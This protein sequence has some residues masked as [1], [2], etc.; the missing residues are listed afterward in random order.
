M[1]VDDDSNDSTRIVPPP[2]PKLPVAGRPAATPSD[3][4]T[5]IQ[6][7]PPPAP[8]LQPPPR[9]SAPPP[10]PPAPVDAANA[11]GGD[12][13]TH[14]IG[15]A[16]PAAK[17]APPPVSPPPP[18]TTPEVRAP[19][20]AQ[21]TASSVAIDAEEATQI[22]PQRRVATMR[23]QRVQPPG[24]SEMIELDRASYL[25]GRSVACDLT[26]YSPTASREH[27]R[28]HNQGGA[29]FIEPVEAREVNVDG[30]AIKESTRLV[31]AMRL[32][33]GGDE[34]IFL[35][36]TA[37]RAAAAAAAPDVRARF[38]LKRMV[39]IVVGIALFAVA[40]VWWLTKP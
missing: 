16:A 36:E 17:L 27:A 11:D 33:L 1:A 5:S 20:P 24:R 3:E 8:A 21:P 39:I 22:L 19:A 13:H 6:A 2:Q 14:I 7:A 12:D 29:W 37:S 23:L 34:L 4:H 35:D 10:S 15:A 26:L 9:V 25:M 38:G 30:V 28:L 32:R 31:H 40:G 18:A